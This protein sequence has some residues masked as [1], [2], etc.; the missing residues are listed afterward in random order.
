MKPGMIR[1]GDLLREVGLPNVLG[2]DSAVARIEVPDVE[3]QR[4]VPHPHHALLPCS[5]WESW[6]VP[7]KVAHLLS[8]HA[9]HNT[10][11]LRGVRELMS[12]R[13]GMHTWGL[14]VGGSGAGK[15]TAAGW[16]LTQLRC[17]RG[18]GRA[19]VTSE[20]IALLPHGTVTATNTMQRLA[21]ASALVLDDVGWN[22]GFDGHLHPTV[23]RLIRKRYEALLPTLCTSNLHPRM[24]WLRYIGARL[25]D[26]WFEIGVYR[27]TADVSMRQKQNQE[28][29]PG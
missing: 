21:D 17:S 6:G 9:L 15:T 16:W 11:A 27:V 2:P 29:F 19:F 14:L 23:Q 7:A 13:Q 3:I 8:T 1:L 22:D 10:Q 25:I 4:P 5:R 20:D 26:R 12:A 28:L 18:H 24:D